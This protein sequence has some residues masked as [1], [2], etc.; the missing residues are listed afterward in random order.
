MVNFAR[1]NKVSLIPRTAGTSLAGQVVGSGIIVDVSVNFREILEVNKEEHWVRVH[2]GVIRDDLNRFL[3]EYGL[4]FGPETSTSSRCMIGGMVGNNACGARSV[5]YGST[6]DHLLEVHAILSDG[7]KTVFKDI[8]AAE[9]LDKANGIGVVGEVE[10][11]IY[12]DIREMLSNE[13]NRSEIERE[14]PKKS[15]PRRNN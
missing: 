1:E 14:F 12:F 11:Q 2:P 5:I 4:F 6:R 8:D 9:L 7:T 15:I 3:A 10:N 13:E